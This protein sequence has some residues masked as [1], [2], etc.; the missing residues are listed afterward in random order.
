MKWSISESLGIDK[1]EEFCKGEFDGFIDRDIAFKEHDGLKPSKPYTYCLIDINNFEK[2][3]SKNEFFYIPRNLV[4]VDDWLLIKKYT[5]KR[6]NLINMINKS[7]IV[8]SPILDSLLVNGVQFE[9]GRNRY[10]L[11][12]DMGI[13]FFP[14]LVPNSIIKVLEDLELLVQTT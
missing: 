5:F 7:G 3:W 2:H 4:G 1:P 8:Y 14:A 6:Q 9:D 11:I 13:K 10:A 12:R